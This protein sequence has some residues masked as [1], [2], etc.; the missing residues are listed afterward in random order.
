MRMKW[1]QA[2]ASLPGQ[3]YTTMAFDLAFNLQGHIEGLRTGHQESYRIY[4]STRTKMISNQAR[5]QDFVQ[6]GANLAW[7]KV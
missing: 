2:T 5:S 1:S 6:E 7:A 4:V 3:H